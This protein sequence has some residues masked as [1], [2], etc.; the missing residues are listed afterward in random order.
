M[1][2]ETSVGDGKVLKGEEYVLKFD[3][4]ALKGDGEAS[5]PLQ[6]CQIAMGKC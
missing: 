6:M 3:V 4:D 5:K 1:A 2:T